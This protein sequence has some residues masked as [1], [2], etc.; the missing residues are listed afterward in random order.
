MIEHMLDSDLEILEEMRTNT[1]ETLHELTFRGPVMLIFL[2]HFGCV[3]CK[4]ALTDLAARRNKFEDLGFQIV[5]VHMS[6]T[7]TADEYFST[8]NLEGITHIN[9]PI[10]RY[11]NAFGLFRGTLTQL[12][13]LQTWIRGYK[14]KKKHNFPLESAKKLGDSF[15]MPGVF[16]IQEG[17][18]KDK[19][20]HSHAAQR[21]DYDRL[22]D[23]CIR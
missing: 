3:F 7:E 21:P 9:D 10:K 1:G 14:V 22:L 19:F 20:V 11:Y 12:F 17:E 6:D 4:E 15:Q 2:R 8:F 23:C 13:G 5:F 18:I 16:V